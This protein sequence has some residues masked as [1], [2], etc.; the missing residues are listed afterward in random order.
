ME[1]PQPNNKKNHRSTKVEE[2]A[3]ADGAKE[4]EEDEE[5]VK[6]MPPPR[7]QVKFALKKSPSTPDSSDD[8]FASEG[9]NTER[10]IVEIFNASVPTDKCRWFDSIQMYEM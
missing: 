5:K 8:P 7:K 9:D 3:A 10:F 1:N 6:D 4:E 2:E